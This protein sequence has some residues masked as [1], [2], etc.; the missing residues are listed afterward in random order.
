MKNILVTGGCGFIGSN[1]IRYLHHLNPALHIYNID[2]LTYAGNQN[3]LKE[4]KGLA[5]YVFIH[6]DI[7]DSDLVERIL[8][9]SNID[10]VVHFAAET[11][12]DRSI[13]GPE[14]FVHTN[15]VGTF[16]L[17]EAVKKVW[18]TQGDGNLADYRFHHISTD[19][20]YGSLAIE[21]PA[22]V[23]TTP[24]TP[25]SPYSASKAASDHLVRAY[26]HTYQLPITI[27]NCSNN[28]GPYQY[29]EKLIPLMVLNGLNGGELPVYGD[30]RQIRDWLYVEDHCEA[31][32]Q[33]LLHGISGETYNVG[34]NTQLS[35]LEVINTICSILDKNQPDSE[36]FPH[37][38]LIKFVDDRPG[39]DRRYAID[40][41]KLS[42][43][44]GWQPKTSF[45]DGIQKTITWYLDNPEW[46]SD[47][48]SRRDYQLW[49]EK[50]YEQRGEDK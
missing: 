18:M 25:N 9:E 11:H 41:T 29:P 19:E 8:I 30:G 27:S 21:D 38:K 36:N 4:L 16:R 31:I 15:I 47:M 34:G 13:Y 48:Y 20:V 10:T 40:C 23:E 7:C 22:F 14:A 39:H 33:I 49:L 6:G 42:Q 43:T 50:N 26:A 28:Y 12:V 3:N 35:N 37:E 17:L 2:S 46:V 45:G 1:F 24:Y 5:N 32:Y 44:L